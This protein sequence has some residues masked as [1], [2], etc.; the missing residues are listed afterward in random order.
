VTMM[1]L[2]RMSFVKSSVLGAGAKPSLRS[3]GKTM[4]DPTTH[5]RARGAFQTQC[6]GVSIRLC[7]CAV[8]V[9]EW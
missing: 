9:V 4:A 2:P 7:R 1:V 5:P 8:V 6:R 3:T